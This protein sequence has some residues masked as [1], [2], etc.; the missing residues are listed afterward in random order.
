MCVPYALQDGCPFFLA[1]STFMIE[2]PH[3]TK[4]VERFSI[5]SVVVKN[6]RVKNLSCGYVISYLVSVRNAE[7]KMR[8]TDLVSEI[9]RVVKYPDFE[10]MGVRNST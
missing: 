4:G 10:T 8:G 7:K 5:I 1:P 3:F 6:A 9:K 2:L